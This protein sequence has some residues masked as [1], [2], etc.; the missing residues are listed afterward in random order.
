MRIAFRITKYNRY[1]FVPL[2]WLLKKRGIEAVPCFSKEEVFA[3]GASFVFFSFMTPFAEDAYKEM[4]ELKE[5]GFKI[6]AGGPH[7]SALSYEV[8]SSGAD[9][10][11]VGEAEGVMDELIND[12]VSGSL[13]ELYSAPLNSFPGYSM[14]ASPYTAAVELVRGCPFGC[15]FCQVSYLFGR[16]PRN[17][18]VDEVL[19]EAQVL[20]K[21]DRRF[22]RFIAPNALS[23]CSHN[24]I[25][26]NVELLEELFSKLKE[27]G[28]LQIF[29]GSFPSEV[30][31]ES[32][33]EEAAALMKRFC[34]N[35]RVVVGAQSGSNERL[36]ELGR[37]HTV[38]DVE[39]A[40]SIL[41]GYGFEVSLDFIFGFPK[42]TEDEQR[43]TLNFIEMMLEK[44]R[45]KI[46]AHAFIPLPGTPYWNEEPSP[47]PRWLKR[48]LHELEGKGLLDGNW[49]QQEYFRRR[50]CRLH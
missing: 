36:K 32:V 15:K 7:P 37:G 13:K 49:A 19:Y 14:E 8:L 40:V 46:H 5:S 28:F 10:V 35:K 45:V 6:V 23:Y 41:N 50:L 43:Q 26:P 30:R 44:Y 33:N 12:I 42:E 48:R 47:I 39:R 38:E 25:E 17:R 2:F 22:I 29:F 4:A 24:G 16:R 20:L 9:A 18:P 11:V 21:R 31:P 1:S 3:S 34:A 27:M